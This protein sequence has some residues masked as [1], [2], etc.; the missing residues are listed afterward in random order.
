[1][2]V[3]GKR[4]MSVSEGRVGFEQCNSA[5][6]MGFMDFGYFLLCLF[7][8]MSVYFHFLSFEILATNF[9]L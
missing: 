2:T 9:A 1:M 5:N 3:D 8:W 7:V 4:G 6:D